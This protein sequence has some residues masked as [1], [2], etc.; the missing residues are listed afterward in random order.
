MAPAGSDCPTPWENRP[1]PGRPPPRDPAATL[2][3][4]ATF[5]A[6]VL[7]LVTASPTYTVSGRVRNSVGPAWDQDAPSAEMKPVT[8]SPRR[9]RATQYG[10]LPPSP[11]LIVPPPFWSRRT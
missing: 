11:A 10:A 8:L 4:V 2:S 3:K 1:T 5:S 6:P 7:R 9:T